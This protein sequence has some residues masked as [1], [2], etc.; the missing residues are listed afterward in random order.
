MH[1]TKKQLQAYQKGDPI[2]SDTNDLTG[3]IVD[4]LNL[5]GYKVWR[6]NNVAVYDKEIGDYRAFVGLLGLPDIIGWKKKTGVWIAVEVKAGEDVLSPEQ[7][8][9][10]Y[11]LEK[12]GG[13]AMV[14]K[15]FNQFLTELTCKTKQRP[16]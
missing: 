4:Y 8:Q 2:P 14:A 10:L 12:A 5:T 16:V 7:I 9:F 11:E 1:W 6:Q 3:A 15:T 13:I